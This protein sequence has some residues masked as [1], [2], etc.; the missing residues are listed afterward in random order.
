MPRAT[1]RLAQARVPYRNAGCKRFRDGIVDFTRWLE[2]SMAM[3]C[4]KCGS[5]FDQRFKCPSCGDR[6]IYHGGRG[7]T[8]SLLSRVRWQE[9]VVGRVA[10]GLVLSQGLFHGFRQLATGILLAFN[11]DGGTQQTTTTAI[12]FVSLQILQLVGV[13]LGGM[14]AGSGH[15]Q[16]LM[17][18]A[19]VGVINGLI[20][21]VLQFGPPAAMSPVVFYGHPVLHV[22][23]GAFGGWIGCVIWQPVGTGGPES[24]VTAAVKAKAPARR[25]SLLAGKVAW[26]R[27]AAGVLLAIVG[28]YYATMTRNVILDATTG[29]LNTTDLQDYVI[30]WELKALAILLGGVAAGMNTRNGLKQG[31]CV[32]LAV[33]LV[34][35]GMETR[36]VSRLLE[37]A[38]LLFAGSLVLGTVGG[39]FG[40]MLFPPVIHRQKP[41]L[42]GAG[43]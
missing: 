40:S 31:L 1:G 9:T 41:R 22:A 4:P 37:W 11:S 7:A 42:I 10:I 5:S 32:G 6:L 43:A 2:V 12:G 27:V 15:R 24:V 20:C 26:V 16:G 19:V 29:R 13:V 25:F 35:V 33:G 30:T 3:V 17:L 34:M 36:G 14:L 28:C 39:W 18:G 23:F 8:R 21:A 38:L